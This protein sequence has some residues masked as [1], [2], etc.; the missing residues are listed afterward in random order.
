[1]DDLDH[2]R[3]FRAGAAYPSDEVTA[4]ARQAL[5]RSLR[6]GRAG[7]RSSGRRRLLLALT[8][9]AAFVFAS[10]LALAAAGIL[11]GP[12]APPEKQR[13]LAELFPP[14]RIGRATTL[15][16][17]DGRTLFG[18]RTEAGGYCFSATSPLD[19]RSEGGHCV[20]QADER[21]LDRRETVAFAMSG[22]SAG[23]YAPGAREVRVTGPGVDVSIPVGANGWWVGEVR[24]PQ[25]PLPPGV[26]SG[27]V[28]A[29][30]VAED[31][32][33]VGR[34]ALLR[35]ERRGPAGAEVYVIVF[36]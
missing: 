19:P 20:S 2:V 9:G 33:V 3:A 36:V 15:A 28:V 11:D 8:A 6:D 35:I 29:A 5:L 32:R 1:M 10:G 23:G 14:L 4:A 16:S 22:A 25:P 12:P 27:T 17:H 24:L 21:A 7:A 26:R 30:A 13:A 31:G 34:D 18:A